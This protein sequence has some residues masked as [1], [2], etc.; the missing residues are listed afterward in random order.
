LW[1]I[2]NYNLLVYKYRDGNI[3]K[4]EGKTISNFERD[5]SSIEK[6]YFWASNRE[7]L[8]DPCE[9]FVSKDNFEKQSGCL[10]FFL[11]TN[12]KSNLRNVNNTL[13]DTISF[14]EKLGIYSLSQTFN[15]EL[16]WAH[17]GNSHK[18]FCIEYK[19]DIL[20]ENY[21]HYFPV[22]YSKEPANLGIPDV[23]NN[24]NIF[25]KIVGWK[26][27][28]WASEKEIR[29]LTDNYG[30]NHYNYKALKSIYFGLR[31]EE[32]LKNKI[33]NRLKGRGI[34]YFQIKQIPKTYRFEAK[35]IKDINSQEITYLKQIPISVTN[36]E[37][38]NFEVKEIRPWKIP[39]RS[40]VK[41]EIEKIISEK[42]LKWLAK[43]IKE[44][45]FFNYELVIIEY[46]T[47]I[48]N[49]SWAISNFKDGKTKITI[50]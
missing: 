6:N 31:M 28:R 17:Y 45:L 14:R 43:T 18:G 5:L 19:F 20:I 29:I 27:P 44:N 25:Q 22:T 41:V 48:N 23:T 34:N 40:N 42:E 4:V 21:K 50:Y 1:L 16:L 7:Q 37:P 26:S 12:S 2:K 32:K 33:M 46:Y 35:P 24:V 9:G 30:G 8:N 47:T 13:E 10:S 11:N 15:D 38:I 36:R 49:Y 39:L 3:E